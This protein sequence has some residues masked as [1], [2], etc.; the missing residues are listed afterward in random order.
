RPH[1][2]ARDGNEHD[3]VWL[4][5]GPRVERHSSIEAAQY[6]LVREK[7]NRGSRGIVVVSCE[8]YRLVG[9]VP[10]FVL[11]RDRRRCC[12]LYRDLR[13]RRGRCGEPQHDEEDKLC[14]STHD[15]PSA[16]RFNVQCSMFNVEWMPSL[17][18]EHSSLNITAKASFSSNAR[19]P[20]RSS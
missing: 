8:D 7:V 10:G 3:T 15:T 2:P 4:D 20:A 11:R 19:A 18:I 6:H 5:R 9:D 14:C 16:D 1:Q 12:R 13:H 17:S